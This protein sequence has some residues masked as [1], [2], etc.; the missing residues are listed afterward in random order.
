MAMVGMATADETSAS[1]CVSDGEEANEC[2]HVD[3]EA[4]KFEKLDAQPKPQALTL[5]ESEA[6]I[7]T[8]PT[9][10]KVCKGEDCKVVKPKVP[11]NAENPI[12]ARV[13]AAGTMALVF[14]SA[15]LAEVWS[16]DKGKK[17]TAVKYAKGEYKCGTGQI[18]DELLYISVSNCSGPAAKGYLYSSKGKKLADV[19]GKDF[20]TYN[21]LPIQVDENTWAFLEESGTQV[22]L[23]D[24][25]TGKL[26]KAIDVSG[27]WQGGAAEPAEGGDA[28]KKEGDDADKKEGGADA[29]ADES[30]SDAPEEESMTP[31]GNPGESSL[32][33][34][35]AGTLIAISGNPKPGNLAVIDVATG[36][37][38]YVHALPCKAK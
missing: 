19:G 27:L 6:R 26:I 32:V 23:H 8:T 21:T 10:I 2:F 5:A 13:N 18:L 12:D 24:G 36:D 3:L 7:E 4:S 11:K 1:F 33:R 29:P 34:G 9:E 14:P 28:D 31:I 38:K 25:K 37:V 30:G 20:G 22:A 16:V 15:G 35:K 17:L